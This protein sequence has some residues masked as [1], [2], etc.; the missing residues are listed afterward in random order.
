MICWMGPRL[1]GEQM[2][3]TSTLQD[4]MCNYELSSN[5]FRM[6]VNA[7][8]E[9]EDFLQFFPKGFTILQG[10]R[11]TMTEYYFKL[12]V[13]GAMFRIQAPYGSGARAME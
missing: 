10:P 9:P 7:Y 3:K 12:K 1:S 13:H 6:R 2:A 5:M 11:S 8:Q 4:K